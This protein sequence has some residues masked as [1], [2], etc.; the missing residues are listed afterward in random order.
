MDFENGVLNF[1]NSMYRNDKAPLTLDSGLK[2]LAQKEIRDYKGNGIPNQSF[3]FKAPIT[4][5]PI[6]GS[7]LSTIIIQ[8]IIINSD[9]TFDFK[10]DQ[11][12]KLGIAF[13]L[14]S[15]S[16]AAL[17]IS[18]RILKQQF[19]F[20]N[21]KS[22][23]I[24]PKSMKKEVKIV[25]P[26][27]SPAN[28]KVLK[29]SPPL[30]VKDRPKKAKEP[31]IETNNYLIRVRSEAQQVVTLIEEFLNEKRRGAQ[32]PELKCDKDT[33]KIF[34][35]MHRRTILSSDSVEKENYSNFESYYDKTFVFTQNQEESMKNF[36]SIV[37]DHLWKRI[38]DETHS[39]ME[40]FKACDTLLVS[41]FETRKFFSA[42]VLLGQKKQNPV[43]PRLDDLTT[44]NEEKMLLNVVFYN[45]IA[46]RSNNDREN[47]KT[48]QL[49]KDRAMKISRE[50][51]GQINKCP[52]SFFYSSKR[53]K[54]LF[55]CVNPNNS[56]VES[57]NLI[58][59][60]EKLQKEYILDENCKGVGIGLWT[61]KDKKLI[62]ITLD[63]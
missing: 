33:L 25:Q 50:Y 15:K 49:L 22:I 2:E 36:V 44:K 63:K 7:M 41:V 20:C 32:L 57:C 17:F 21:Q 12:S 53:A 48:T 4:Q 55:L 13:Q 58:K 43:L 42:V 26:V 11:I 1:I 47:L 30:Q 9:V 10:S 31:I 5:T 8:Q 24:T 37:Q 28:S 52:S 61:D 6:D 38:T 46:F 23:S 60:L 56:L 51:K 62:F 27:S 40:L 45:V 59:N 18:N 34:M 19:E 35:E 14:K 29:H 3:Y 39:Y 54:G 16:I